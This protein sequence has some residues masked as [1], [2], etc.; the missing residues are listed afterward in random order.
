MTFKITYQTLF[1]TN[2]PSG[3]ASLSVGAQYIAPSS[4]FLNLQLDR[5]QESQLIAN[6]KAEE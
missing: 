3:P 2:K 4:I 6:K 1:Q 5:W